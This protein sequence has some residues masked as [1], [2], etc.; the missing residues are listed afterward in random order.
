MVSCGGD[1]G[2]STMISLLKA[3]SLR[4]Y[5]NCIKSHVGHISVFDLSYF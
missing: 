4:L 2:S 5:L 1:S 3:P